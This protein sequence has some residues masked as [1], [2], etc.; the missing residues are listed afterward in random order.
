MQSYLVHL[1]EPSDTDP[2]ASEATAFKAQADDITHAIEQA[3]NAYPGA[4]IVSATRLD[5]RAAPRLMCEGEAADYVLVPDAPSAWVRI[6]NIAVYLRR[7]D[8]GVIV[9]LF[10]SGGEDEEALV[11]CHEFFNE[12]AAAVVD[13]EL[14]AAQRAAH[15]PYTL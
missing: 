5:G 7:T 2:N 10:P 12:A 13:R 4:D 14:T 15:E 9:E 11:S 3:Q 8:E 6:D 1:I